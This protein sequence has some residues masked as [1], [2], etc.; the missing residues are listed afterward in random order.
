[1]V[2]Y[3]VRSQ[4]PEREPQDREAQRKN[5]KTSVPCGENKPCLFNR[6]ALTLF[7]LSPALD[8]YRNMKLKDHTQT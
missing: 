1:M 4:R 7:D 6:R 5:K 8:S 3:Q 2:K